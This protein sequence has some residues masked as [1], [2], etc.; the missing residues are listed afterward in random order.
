[1]LFEM[2]VKFVLFDMVSLK[3]NLLFIDF[4]EDY[5]QGWDVFYVCVLNEIGDKVVIYVMIGLQDCG[6]IVFFG[7]MDVVLVIGQV[8]MMDFF[9]LWVENGCVYGCGVVDMKVFDVFV[10]VLILEFQ[11]VNFMMLIYIL[12]FYD[13][14]MIC[15]GVVDVI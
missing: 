6:G 10:L 4:V 7:Y 2:L 15:F 9:M 12:L 5:L 8:W 3:F 1:M 11:V 14:E 13:E